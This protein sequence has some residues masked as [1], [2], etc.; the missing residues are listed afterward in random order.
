MTNQNNSA[1]S[2][3]NNDIEFDISGLESDIDLHVAKEFTEYLD[4]SEETDKLKVVS[5]IDGQVDLHEL[6]FNV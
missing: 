3:P 6:S 1:E 4:L 2:N 5:D